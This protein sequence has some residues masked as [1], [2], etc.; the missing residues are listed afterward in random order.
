M[1]IPEAA[2]EFLDALDRHD[3]DTLDSFLSDDFRSGGN[4]VRDFNKMDMLALLKAYFSAFSDYA[5][6]FSEATQR[7]DVL[8]VKYAVSGTHDGVLDLT[9][10][11]ITITAEPTGKTINL[12]ESSAEFTFDGSDKVVSQVLNQAQGATMTALLEQLGVEAPPIE[13][14]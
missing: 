4:T 2:H 7:D 5:F 3:L 10:L 14:G 9:P 13:K 6:N 11:G 1:P 8:S 12:P